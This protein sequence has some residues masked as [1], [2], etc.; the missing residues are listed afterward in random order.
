MSIYVAIEFMA[1][2][3]WIAGWRGGAEA[4]MAEI[5]MALQP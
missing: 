1:Q 4:E 2:E 3:F 5:Y